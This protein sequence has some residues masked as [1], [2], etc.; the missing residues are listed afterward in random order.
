M[1]DFCSVCGEEWAQ[2]EIEFFSKDVDG[3]TARDFHAGRGC[4]TCLFGKAAPRRNKNESRPDPRQDT[5]GWLVIG[6]NVDPDDFEL[7]DDAVVIT[8]R[9]RR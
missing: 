2:D 1:Y 8:H 9:D 7:P 4:P 5:G 6:I 3:G